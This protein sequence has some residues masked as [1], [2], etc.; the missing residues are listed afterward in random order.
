[1]DSG[2]VIRQ[3]IYLRE[4]YTMS[5]SQK[6][7]SLSPDS[8][9][10]PK[11]RDACN[12]N[13]LRIFLSHKTEDGEAA[14]KIKDVLMRHAAGKLEVFT[15][16]E[17][18]AGLAWKPKIEE[19]AKEANWFVLLFSHPDQDWGWCLYEAGIFHEHMGK[20]GRLVCLRNN[21]GQT[22]VFS[23]HPAVNL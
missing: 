3:L 10:D 16:G 7:S 11:T 2:F 1:M 6:A 18:Q 14:K 9:L 13:T 21:R 19:N 22:T 20:H 23:W 4:E 15:F 12:R 5:N 8:E 17:I